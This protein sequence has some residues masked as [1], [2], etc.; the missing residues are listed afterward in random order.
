MTD[1]TTLNC[2]N[3][4]ADEYHFYEYVPALGSEYEVVWE[5]CE[6]CCE[7]VYSV[8]ECISEL[9]N[10]QERELWTL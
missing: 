3:P 2:P 5:L 10:E 9:D 6:E 4:A 7:F 1:C 8:V